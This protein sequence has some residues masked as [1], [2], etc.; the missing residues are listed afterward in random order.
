MRKTR[1]VHVHLDCSRPETRFEAAWVVLLL[2]ALD[3]L[4]QLCFSGFLY[5]CCKQ[6]HLGRPHSSKAEQSKEYHDSL[7]SKLL[8]RGG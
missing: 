8:P 6:N 2:G 7:P 1:K 5:G 4:G 3:G